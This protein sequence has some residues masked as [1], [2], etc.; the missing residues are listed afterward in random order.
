MTLVPN[1]VKWFRCL[2][3]K[4]IGYIVTTVVTMTDSEV[5]RIVRYIVIFR[6]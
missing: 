5:A 2:M 4:W 3:E 1:V 6:A